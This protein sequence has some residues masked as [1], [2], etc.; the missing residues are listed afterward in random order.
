MSDGMICMTYNDVTNDVTNDYLSRLINYSTI[1][2]D[3]IDSY[4]HH[5]L[6]QIECNLLTRRHVS[7]IE[8]VDSSLFNVCIAYLV[9][10]GSND[11]HSHAFQCFLCDV[12]CSTCSLCSGSTVRSFV[13]MMMMMIVV[14]AMV[15]YR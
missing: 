9:C 10:D 6:F 4:Y 14:M 8:V 1:Y 11:A 3:I 5:H 2:I 15:V 12:N 13:I 7:S